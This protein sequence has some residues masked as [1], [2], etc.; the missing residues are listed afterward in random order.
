MP[1]NQNFWD[2]SLKSSVGESSKE[3]IREERGEKWH[4]NIDTKIMGAATDALGKFER[5]KDA[6]ISDFE[7]QHLHPI[8][9]VCVREW[10]RLRGELIIWKILRVKISG[11]FDYYE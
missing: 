3:E 2:D 5:E 1:C 4:E 11:R 7:V 10:I 8:V 6:V 9:F